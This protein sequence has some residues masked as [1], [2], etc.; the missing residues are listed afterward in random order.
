MGNRTALKDAW[1]KAVTRANVTL[2]VGFGCA[3]S[4][5]PTLLMAATPDNMMSALVNK[6]PHGAC[7]P[8]LVAAALACLVIFLGGRR[9]FAVLERTVKPLALGVA[10]ALMGAVLV[11]PLVTRNSVSVTGDV[12]IAVAGSLSVLLYLFWMQLFGRLSAQSMFLTLFLSQV[13]TCAI[14]A[15]ISIANIYTVVATSI[16]LPLVSTICLRVGQREHADERPSSEVPASQEGHGA[17]TLMLVKLAAIVFAWGVIDHLFRSEFDAFMRTQV[18]TSPFA[19]AYHAAAFVVVVAAVAF[20]YALLAYRERFQFGH[21]Y[22]M[23]FLLGLASIL[24]LPIVLA[25]QATIVGYTCSVIMYQLV[26]LLVWVIAASVFRDSP[27]HAPGFF[28]LVYGF[29]SLGSLGGALFSSVF[30]QHLTMDNVHLIVFAA[31]LAV[32]V[33]Y[34]VMFTEADANALVQIVPYKRKAPFK[35]KCQAVAQEYQLSPRETEIA[36]LIAQGRDS[37]HIEKKLFLS[38][39]TV[40]THRM[41]LYQKLDIH[42]RQELLDIIEAADA[43]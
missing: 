32:A 37:A 1:S 25:G 38:R 26:F 11:L 43:S 30:V 18:T 2:A 28:G 14:N 27:T 39:S 10:M 12:V 13:L 40:Q 42:N 15:I 33:G 5:S 23:I 36:M 3:V 22:R 7:M 19:V 17:S 9:L 6:P 8:S 41:H 21:L 16:A 35:A 31:V 20:A 29:W 24:L 34:A 4:I